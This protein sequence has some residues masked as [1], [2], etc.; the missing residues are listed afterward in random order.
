M[1]SEKYEQDISY[2]NMHISHML[3]LAI[4]Y[5]LSYIDIG[6]LYYSYRYESLVKFEIEVQ[7]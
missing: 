4:K 1:N 5:K 6:D 3:T 7:K 2:R